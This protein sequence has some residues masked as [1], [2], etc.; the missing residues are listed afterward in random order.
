MPQITTSCKTDTP[1]ID[2]S[3]IS[4]GTLTSL[5]L[6][7]SRRFYE[8]VLGLEVIQVSTVSLNIRK[9]SGHVYVVVETGEPSSMGMFD[10]NGIDVGTR[11]AVDK[12]YENLVAVKEEYGLGRIHKPTDQHG[13]YSFYFSDLDGNWWEIQ[14]GVA[15]GN[16]TLFGDPKTDF[17][18]R[19]EIDDEMMQHIFD[20]D[21]TLKENKDQP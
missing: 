13:M 19:T 21:L 12:A 1:L 18:G 14:Q 6:Q 8:E 9:G 5:D 15:G 2:A 10:H 16:A 3:L 4:H 20:T 17:T 7:A 11:D